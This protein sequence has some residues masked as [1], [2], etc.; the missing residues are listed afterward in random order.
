MREM[1]VLHQATPRN[2][3]EEQTHN[4]YRPTL[5]SIPEEVL[6]P[7]T[8]TVDSPTK[9]IITVIVEEN[10]EDEPKYYNETN[11][12]Q[13]LRAFDILHSI[14]S[15]EDLS[16]NQVTEMYQKLFDNLSNEDLAN[17]AQLAFERA[18]K[19]KER[20][21]RHKRNKQAKRER[22]ISR[23]ASIWAKLPSYEKDLTQYG[24]ESNPGP[25][26][27]KNSDEDQ[28]KRM[29]DII[30]SDIVGDFFYPQPT[31]APGGAP[32]F[33][34]LILTICLLN[35][36]VTVSA[37]TFFTGCT[38]EFVSALS[39]TSMSPLPGTSGVFQDCTVSFTLGMSSTSGS[40]EI[41][42]GTGIPFFKLTA[43]SGGY[44]HQE[45]STP[46]MRYACDAQPVSVVVSGGATIC[47]VLKA[48]C[49]ETGIQ[50]PVWYAQ[51]SQ[52]L[53]VVFYTPQHVIVDNTIAVNV[54]DIASSAKF[55]SKYSADGVPDE[56]YQGGDPPVFLTPNKRWS[57]SRKQRNKDAHSLNGNQKTP[58][59]VVIA[60]YEDEEK[61]LGICDGDQ[62]C[63]DDVL[64]LEL[65]EE[66]RQK[67]VKDEQY[68]KLVKAFK[69][70]LQNNKTLY[71]YNRYL[72]LALLEDEDTIEDIKSHK[73]IGLVTSDEL[74]Q[75]NNKEI[76]S[77]S[78]MEDDKV[79]GGLL[80]RI[81]KDIPTAKIE[82]KTK[83][84]MLNFADKQS[85]SATK[86]SNYGQQI[87]RMKKGI[88]DHEDL[89]MWLVYH[90]PNHRF[91]KH[92]I[93]KLSDRWKEK[94]PTLWSIIVIE[95]YLCKRYCAGHNA[96]EVLSIMYASGH[97]NKLLHN[98]QFTDI[99]THKFGENVETVYGI[100]RDLA[101]KE[102]DEGAR[103]IKPDHTPIRAE[104][105]PAT[106][107]NQDAWVADLTEYG[108]EP[109][110]GPFEMC[111]LIAKDG[112]FIDLTRYG[113]EPNPGPANLSTILAETLADVEQSKNMTNLKNFTGTGQA[114]SAKEMIGK[115]QG[116]VPTYSIHS[117]TTPA[118]G[119]IS[120]SY[121][122]ST[123]QMQVNLS[124]CPREMLLIPRE[125]FPVSG[126]APV[127]SNFRLTFFSVGSSS[128]ILR[129][130]GLG[131]IWSQASQQMS[132]ARLKPN[133]LAEN[134]FKNEDV[135][136]L[137]NSFFNGS[138]ESAI[139]AQAGGSDSMVLVGIRTGQ[140][141]LIYGGQRP[142]TTLPMAGLVTAADSFGKLFALD[143]E[144]GV[145]PWDSATLYGENGGN[146][147]DVLTT[148]PF[149]PFG[150]NFT[151]V[152]H[153]VA[154]GSVRFVTSLQGLTPDELNRVIA[155]PAG[156]LTS[157]G[158]QPSVVV[159]IILALLAP[160]PFALF[161]AHL[162]VSDFNNANQTVIPSTY[163][164][165]LIATE[166]ITDPIVLLPTQTGTR[167][168]NTQAQAN[169]SSAFDLT[170]G[171][172]ATQDHPP[173]GG[174]DVSYTGVPI[175][176]SLNGFIY[177]W[178]DYFNSSAFYNIGM[179]MCQMCNRLDDFETGV[180]IAMAFGA[181]Y[182]PLINT[183]AN[184]ITPHSSIQNVDIQSTDTVVF[185]TTRP[186]R[187]TG[188]FPLPQ[189]SVYDIMVPTFSAN[190]LSAVFTGCV[191]PIP[192][193]GSGK[194]SLNLAPITVA[195]EAWD[196]HKYFFRSLAA[197]YQLFYTSQQKNVNFWNSAVFFRRGNATYNEYAYDN[198]I[199]YER[200]RRTVRQ[201]YITT[202]SRIPATATASGT[203]NKIVEDSLKLVLPR[204]SYGNN[205]LAYITP[206]NGSLQVLD[207]D[208]N[209]ETLWGY[210]GIKGLVNGMMTESGTYIPTI[211]TDLE[212]Y[213]IL[214]AIPKGMQMWPKPYSTDNYGL[215][216]PNGRMQ[217]IVVGDVP[218][219]SFPVLDPGKNFMG[220]DEDLRNADEVIY[221][222]RAGLA[223]TL[224]GPNISFR[225]T[226]G[227]VPTLVRPVLQDPT[228]GLVTDYAVPQLMQ[229]DAACVGTPAAA[230]FAYSAS[231]VWP[232]VDISGGRWFPFVSTVNAS[233][234]QWF[235]RKLHIPGLTLLF[236]RSLN[237][238]VP[239][240]S[241]T[242]PSDYTLDNEDRSDD[243]DSKNIDAGAL[244]SVMS[245]PLTTTA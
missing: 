215:I 102:I 234:A 96:K 157:Y 81:A 62:T 95:S 138:G 112:P 201:T 153:S 64:D 35:L 30:M 104:Q 117:A 166:G 231:A 9:G 80:R 190:W 174:I 72:L 223:T 26:V 141:A 18:R 222:I 107:P 31:G 207:P 198:T 52:M 133:S 63:F 220:S 233:M 57:K 51:Q 214:S 239:F 193:N 200:W 167:P 70:S 136:L 242:T 139:P 87:T 173:N 180:S 206:P 155:I 1:S 128:S 150:A 202:S 7:R 135:N 192:Q 60:Q 88:K 230:T 42:V 188:D 144:P 38:T 169:D 90:K 65:E 109:N 229:P 209:L 156:L 160:G 85:H 59:L 126:G 73:K 67:A 46:T 181:R 244:S 187:L 84:S 83:R 143:G 23:K 165:G 55:Y 76:S 2:M 203:I 199:N 122:G 146:T 131:P 224:L 10:H 91:A 36:L 94:P 118:A 19:K 5:E 79:S 217:N 212:M 145:N 54:T 191:V 53:G 93:H 183:L 14:K 47:N 92:V 29:L 43:T 245:S 129:P 116:M 204:D 8:V 213:S 100:V 98:K 172:S 101:L 208:N 171:P 77:M 50:Y 44:E 225:Y 28:R 20:R 120:T 210:A 69:K 41:D 140:Y 89:A 4:T 163:T 178:Q 97:Q 196:A 58:D 219:L 218:Y 27:L 119:T 127:A 56:Y 105:T 238:P 184:G 34:K 113:V 236:N 39:T 182:R 134:N 16:K 3:N 152:G 17:L 103:Y 108:I 170:W 168:P 177:S 176:Y 240:T 110:P 147:G 12:L 158:A 106:A 228:S 221:S 22:E 75:D 197:S 25:T 40:C 37:N 6:L 235:A 189:P 61:R 99:Y 142:S 71:E 111:N 194:T 130:Y 148:N 227:T 114:F 33:R 32:F 216:P 115:I 15:C 13:L 151:G 161:N 86:S 179:N 175:Y 11:A 137:G 82:Q 211:L 48:V 226:N 162:H 125:V 205:L 49:A 124:V 195:P 121:V 241:D 149:F 45:V 186:T 237:P 21:D 123:A 132:D 159:A 243:P 24:I 164:A 66:L 232:T 74:S 154:C 68:T 78:D 185:N